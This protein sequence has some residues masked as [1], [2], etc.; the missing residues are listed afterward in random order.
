MFDICA[1]ALKSE[2]IDAAT[3]QDMLRRI[4]SI[5]ENIKHSQLKQSIQVFTKLKLEKEKKLERYDKKDLNKALKIIMY[6][7]LTK[8]ELL[9]VDRSNLD[10]EKE[11]KYFIK[12]PKFIGKRD[13]L[14]ILGVSSAGS[15]IEMPSGEE[16]LSLEENRKDNKRFTRIY[17]KLFKLMSPG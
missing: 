8:M 1:K 17:N 7:R 16:F 9:P 10:D 11:E 15:Y 14:P 4:S 12:T 13:E 3:K 6:K 2:E 5:K